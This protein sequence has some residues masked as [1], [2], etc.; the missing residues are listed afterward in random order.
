MDR[1]WQVNQLVNYNPFRSNDTIVAT[2]PVCQIPKTP[3][4]V[5][6]TLMSVPIGSVMQ[7]GSQNWVEDALQ[8]LVGEGY[9]TVA[10]RA[11]ALDQMEDILLQGEEDAL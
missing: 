1:F 3:D 7:F 9:M 8:M 2:A 4:A 6:S 5:V 10:E 11:E